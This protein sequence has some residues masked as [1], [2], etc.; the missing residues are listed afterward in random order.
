M[1]A[2]LKKIYRLLRKGKT[3]EKTKLIRNFRELDHYDLDFEVFPS[4][5]V[6]IPKQLP[7]E[8]EHGITYKF[9]PSGYRGNVN[10]DYCIIPTEWK[11]VNNYC[12]WTFAE[13][14]LLILA[15]SSTA[16]NIILPPSL[17]NVK[18]PF[19]K[20][21]F[22]LLGQIFPGKKISCKKGILLPD[23]LIPFN[24]DTSCNESLIGKCSYKHYHHSR[25]TPYLIYVLNKIKPLILGDNGP[26][27]PRFYINR[28]TRRLKNELQV[29]QYLRSE[30]FDILNLEDLSLDQQIFLFSNARE[31]IGFHGAGLTNIV[32]CHSETKIIEI[33]DAD[34]VY[35]SYKDGVVIPG[36]KAT[37]TYFHMVAHMKGVP[38]RVIETEDYFLDIKKLKNAINHN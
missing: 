10:S 36:K 9:G 24:H 8:P 31:I 21:W 5:E 19:Q 18:L 13:L 38:Y 14:P 22:E 28:K 32:F 3:S 2:L 33:V 11:N 15:F 27:S 26:M 30:G 20:R 6:F 29:Q 25:A 17:I 23:S 37:R 12:H 35:P 1:N 7:S 16:K 34:C 4:R